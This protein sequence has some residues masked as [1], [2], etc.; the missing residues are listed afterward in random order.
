MTRELRLTPH[1]VLDTRHDLL[2]RL[3]GVS[4][5]NIIGETLR[6]S[7]E[8]LVDKAI[9]DRAA[10]TIH[11]H[12]RRSHMYRVSADM[13]TL[14]EHA[15]SLLRDVDTFDINT[16]PSEFG[17]V[18]FDRPIRVNDVWGKTMLVHACT[19]GP[20]DV[21]RRNAPQPSQ[22]TARGVFM[23]M[24]NDIDIE[25]DD[26]TRMMIAEAGE[27]RCRRLFGRWGF[28]GGEIL[29]DDATLG[30]LSIDP[31][32]RRDSNPEHRPYTNTFRILAA[33]FT[34]FTQ[35]IA[36]VQHET[37]KIG[38]QRAARHAGVENVDDITVVALRRPTVTRGGTTRETEWT[39]RWIVEGHWHRYRTGVGRQVLERR[40][41]SDYVKGPEDRPLVIKDKIY[42]LRR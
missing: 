21:I 11:Y 2:Q 34:M 41:V 10:A 33:L 39:H 3:D 4:L 6:L 7:W 29:I 5:P 1:Q 14:V 17:Y 20:V 19:W 36:D 12:T 8:W 13:V 15:A 30:P 26:Y 31:R 23:S 27:A 38:T 32:K 35:R 18:R 42:D 25:P 40:W 22:R 28:I 37:P 16:L 24:W 9:I